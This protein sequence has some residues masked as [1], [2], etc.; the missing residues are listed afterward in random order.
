MT[1]L[2]WPLVIGFAHASRLGLSAYLI[3]RRRYGDGTPVSIGFDEDYLPFQ[4][5]LIVHSSSVD[6]GLPAKHHKPA[7]G[8]SNSYIPNTVGYCRKGYVYDSRSKMCVEQ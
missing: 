4:G 5:S 8:Q 7:R 6:V 1:P 2:L 3:D